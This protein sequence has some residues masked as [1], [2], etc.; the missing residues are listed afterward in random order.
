MP[1]FNLL[2][3]ASVI[4]SGST[5]ETFR[6]PV[7]FAGMKFGNADTFYE[8]QRTLVIPSINDVFKQEI[9][10]ASQEISSYSR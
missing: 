2:L 8:I 5:Y 9:E 1:A 3:S 4:F 6:K 7:E 10:S